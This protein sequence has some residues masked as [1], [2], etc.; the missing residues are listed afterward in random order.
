MTAQTFKQRDRPPVED[1]V[2]H[3]I[4]LLAEG[5]PP[6]A[7]AAMIHVRPPTLATWQRSAHFQALLGCLREMGDLQA[8]REALEDLTP[9]AIAALERALTGS[10]D[11]LAVQAAR[12][13]LDRVGLIRHQGSK[14]DNIPHTITVEYR[15]HDGKPQ[16]IAPWAE[17]HPVSPR[18][19]QGGGL[20]SPL[21]E[22]GD[23]QDSA[24]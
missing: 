17:R 11:R 19:L 3:A 13:V 23:G 21:R 15:T 24:G 4:R 20:R 6:D 14:D 7:V 22:D 5:Y 1:R 8:A 18:A 16:S 12:D 10:D 9:D 2:C